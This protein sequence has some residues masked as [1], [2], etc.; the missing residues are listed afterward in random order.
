MHHLPPPIALLL[1]GLA[2]ST[3]SWEDVAPLLFEQGIRAVAIDRVGFGRTERPQQANLLPQLLQPPVL[4]SLVKAPLADFIESSLLAP[5]PVPPP[6]VPQP[7]REAFQ[8]V[9]D[10]LPPPNQALATAVRR[11]SLLAPKLPW[12]A[13]TQYSRINPY[14][15]EFAVRAM[16]ALVRDDRFLLFQGKNAKTKKP[17]ARRKLYLVGHSAG[18][19]IAL[20]AYLDAT[21]T[22]KEYDRNGNNNNCEV[23]GVALVAPAVL[24]PKEDLG[25]YEKNSDKDA[26]KTDYSS[27]NDN[28]RLRVFQ[29]VLALPDA[30]VVP[31]VRRIYDGR[32]LTEAVFNQTSSSS[33]SVERANYLAD[34]Y[35]RPVEEFPDDWDIA[36][37]NVYRA[38]FQAQ[39][40]N[41]NENETIRL[42]GRSLLQQVLLC[43]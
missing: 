18:G 40:D 31:I 17:R 38:D 9:S 14:S 35:K 26:E 8:Q 41:N 16:G 15:S 33:I 1:H 29:S 10:I 23:S 34:K 21:T 28:L 5:L 13:S 11:P 24:D 32:N 4:P 22:N 37:L 39:E 25:I 42:R 20:K 19:P 30:L 36:L 7:L 3:D 12:S 27:D 43:H 2:G 6:L